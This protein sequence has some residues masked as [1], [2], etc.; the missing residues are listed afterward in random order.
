MLRLRGG[1]G[2][3]EP[4]SAAQATAKSTSQPEMGI[5]AGGQIDQVVKRDSGEYKWD[6][7][8]TKVFN[9]QVLNSL[10][11]KQ[12]TGVAPP[13]SP[14]SPA[15]YAKHGYPFFTMYEEPSTV[16]GEFSIVKSVGQIDGSSDP[17]IAPRLV[18]ITKKTTSM[19]LQNKNPCVG[20]FNPSGP[21][22]VFK[23]LEE[24]EKAVRAEGQVLF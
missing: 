5:A 18:D 7:T 20:F 8:Q 6:A 12:I 21:V 22:L 9:V 14:I 15:T 23:S 13:A 17:S 3:A 1:G 2:G 19:T 10:H 11:F 16:A 4:P 24:L